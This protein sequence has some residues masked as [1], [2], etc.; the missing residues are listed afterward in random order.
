MNQYYDD[1][2]IVE[3]DTVIQ[4]ENNGWYRFAETIFFGE[5]GGMPAD[6]GTINGMPVTGLKWDGDVLWHKTEGELQD[7]VHLSVD[8]ETRLLNAALQSALHLMDGYYRRSGHRIISISTQSG[9]QWYEVDRKD[10]PEEH[11]Q[12][13]QAYMNDAI[14]RNKPLTITYMNGRDWPDEHYHRFEELRV[15]T[16]GDLDT[17]PCGTL[18]V[19]S[20]GQIGTMS[21]LSLEKTSRGTKIH[22]ACSL[23][24]NQLLKQEY[25]TVSEIHG[26]VGGKRDEL[27]TAVRQ[28]IEQNRKLKKDTADIKALAVTMKAEELASRE[29]TVLVL[30]KDYEGMLREISQRLLNRITETK[31]I[32]VE[33]AEPVPFAVLSPSGNARNI[34]NAL[35]EQLSAGGGGSP[36]IV[37]GTVPCGPDI[38]QDFFR[39]NL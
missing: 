21:F 7:P 31:A 4:E 5:K 16:F 3:L 28:L 24:E 37:S 38:L 11:L 17:Q 22:V 25:L 6:T 19:N 1:F 30:E 36:K 8:R 10:L 32:V 14:L 15:V 27:V 39:N 33:G 13:V 34:M 20:T 18:H 23:A 35:K 12:E 2:E 26:L 29:D 9:N